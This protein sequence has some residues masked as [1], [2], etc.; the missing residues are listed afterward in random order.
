VSRARLSAPVAAGLVLALGGPALLAVAADRALADRG[1]VAQS[2]IGQL[3]LWVLIGAVAALVLR[4]ERRPLASLGLRPLGVRS[5][6]WGFGAAAVLSF[7]IVPLASG[8]V[9]AL[10][11]AGFEHGLSRVRAWPLWLRGAAVLTGGLAE[12]ALYRGYA[13]TRLEEVTGSSAFA[14]ALSVACFALAHGPLWGSGPVVAFLLSGG[15]LAAFFLWRR[16]LLAN[17]VAHVT[18][19]ALGLVSDPA[20]CQ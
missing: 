1:A 17:V 9:S 3:A 2:I 8:L 5:L 11:L 12:E 18:V 7:A 15:F 6:L 13:I 20:A 10:G 16:D 4:F 14:A 19:D